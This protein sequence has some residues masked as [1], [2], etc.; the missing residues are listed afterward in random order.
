MAH[1]AVHAAQETVQKVVHGVKDLVG[2]AEQRGP[3]EKT[4]T[5]STDGAKR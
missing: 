5:K 4:D 1:K 2:K 3:K